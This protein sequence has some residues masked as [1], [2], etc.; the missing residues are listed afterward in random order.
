VTDEDAFLEAIRAEPDD[1]A[2]RLVFADW[3]EEQGDPRAEFIRVQCELARPGLER[4]RRAELASRERALRQRYEQE[5]LGP[6]RQLGIPAWFHRGLVEEVFLSAPRFLEEAEALFRAAPLVRS[7][8]LHKAE[9]RVAA[10]AESPH[11]ARLDFLNLYCN[12]IG[13]EGAAL[14]ARS[15]HLK[16]LSA[17]DLRCARIG[18]DGVSA[19]AR[20]PFLHRLTFLNLGANGITAAGAVALATAP[21][22]ARLTTLDLANN[23]IGERGA[24][25]LSQSPY[26]TNLTRLDVTSN[27]VGTAGALL[28]TAFG[29]RAL[30]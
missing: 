26:L 20:S 14:L 17:L 21:H 29:R 8:R 27:G 24:M 28:R 3:L 30:A 16:H 9:G 7:V 25:A 23:A 2:P 5:W 4:R 11:L 19:L 13:P 15:P 1:D 12:E 6:L 18:D 22:L 10:L